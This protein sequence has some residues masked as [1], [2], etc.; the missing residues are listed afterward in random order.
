MT[1]LD[2]AVSRRCHKLFELWQTT[3]YALG[4]LS[5]VRRRREPLVDAPERTESTSEAEY[6]G[7]IPVIG[8]VIGS[9]LTSSAAVR[10]VRTPTP[11]VTAVKAE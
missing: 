8:T 6:A 4:Q 5:P 7:S 2:N 1:K 3:A 11:G 9:T 10:T